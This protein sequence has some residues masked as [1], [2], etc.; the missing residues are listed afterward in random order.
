ML[1]IGAH[2]DGDINFGNAAELLHTH[3]VELREQ[4]LSKASLCEL[5]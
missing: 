1:V 4:F 3:P 5:M 2:L